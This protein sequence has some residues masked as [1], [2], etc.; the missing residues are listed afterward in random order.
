[1]QFISTIKSKCKKF[2]VTNTNNW[3]SSTSFINYNLKKKY[4]LNFPNKNTFTK[5]WK[6]LFLLIMTSKLMCSSSHTISLH[7]NIST[8]NLCIFTA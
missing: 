1:M 6:Q 5:W 3:G 4:F 7:H 8:W 2:K